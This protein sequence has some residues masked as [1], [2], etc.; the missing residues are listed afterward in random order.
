MMLIMPYKS[1]IKFACAT[2]LL[3]TLGACAA[4]ATNAAKLNDAD[5]RRE[6][7]KQKEMAKNGTKKQIVRKHKDIAYYQNRLNRVAGPLEKSAKKYCKKGNCNYAFKIADREELNAW[8]DGKSVNFTPIMID[9]LETDQELAVVVAHELSHNVMGHIG[10]QKHN[11]ILG[12]IADVAAAVN[13]I[14]TGGLFGSIGQMSYSQGFENEADY[15]AIYIMANAGYDISNVNHLW[16]KMSMQTPQGIHSSFFSSHPSNPE[17]FLRMQ[18][19]IDE[20]KAKKLA[21][22]PLEPNLKS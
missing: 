21:H 19:T 16:R 20:V 6:Q 17:R 4:P 5:V 10:K 8:A 9:F 2:I 22:K 15:I 3:A 7:Q 13:G 1:F 18:K 11:T 14:D 12:T